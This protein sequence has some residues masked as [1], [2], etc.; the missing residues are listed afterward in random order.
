MSRRGAFAAVIS[1][2]AAMALASGSSA[3]GGAPRATTQAAVELTLVDQ[4]TWVHAGDEFSVSV[5]VAGASAGAALQL[6]VHDRLESR[7]GFQRTLDGEVGGTAATIALRPLAEL[8]PAG[9]PLTAGFV[10]GG[11]AGEGL[12][13]TGVYPVDVQVVDAQ[14]TVLD[15]LLT[16][17]VYL[18]TAEQTAANG[19]VPLAVAVVVDVSAPPALQPDGKIDVSDGTL[20]L[21]RERVALLTDAADI[22]LTVAPLPESLDGFADR[23]R[24]GAVVVDAL[25]QAAAGRPVLARP[26]TDIDLTELERAGLIGEANAQAEAGADV[27][28]RRF[29]QEPL[30]GIWLSGPTLGANAARLAVDLGITRALVPPTAIEEQS[31]SISGPVPDAPVTLGDGGPLAMVSDDEL[32]TRL[33]DDDGVLGG[34]RFLAEL[35][36]W[37][38]E[39]PTRPRAV[40]VHIPGDATLDRAAAARALTGLAD[41]QAAQPVTLD[42]L[43]ASV[44]PLADDGSTT[45][46]ATPHEATGD[47]TSVAGSVERVGDDVR[48]VASTV[49]DEA[50]G[51]TLAR[52]LLLATGS[53]TPDDQRRAYVDRVSTE[54]GTL[55]DAIELPDEFRITLTSRTSTIPVNINNRS[56][57]P[58]E[59]RVE[60]SSSQLEFPDG[61]VIP[62]ELQPGGTRLEV[63]VRILTSGA[64][65]LDITVT[66]PDGSIE[67]DRT[68][69]DV[70]STA[71]T[72]VGLLL[73]IGAGLFLAVWWARHWRRTRRSRH[74][75]PPGSAPAP[76]DADSDD[77]LAR[78]G[79]AG[80]NDVADYHPAHMA[81]PRSRS[82]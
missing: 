3:A 11:D 51:R 32:L 46:T 81:A 25:V 24:Q 73:S 72:G 68:T 74:L 39:R 37:W 35:A 53:A 69:F 49:G 33:T 4:T 64:F 60:L 59:V 76:A 55:S 61:D 23:D 34:Q 29:G 18:P 41:G 6:V 52:S 79:H 7:S 12:D 30:P 2:T 17:L 63:P 44:A 50:A 20:E 82:D 48:G 21:A 66:S 80:T 47:L 43:F 70:R 40:A 8:G 38:L 56:D 1:L 67:L 10:V 15:S 65:P 9:Q 13:G 77:G 5:Q 16:H 57:Q 14:G 54:L 78:A 22:P 75:M 26:Y 36:I 28:R 19:F 31:G 42:D 58:L 27:V 45:V 62:I 71:V